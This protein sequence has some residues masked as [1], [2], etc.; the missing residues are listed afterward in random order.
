MEQEACHADDHVTDIR[1]QKD[2][3][4]LIPNTTGYANQ[5]QVNKYRICQCVHE[6]GDV[7]RDIVVLQNSISPIYMSIKL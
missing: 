6:F 1:H 7:D 3:W 5:C 2:T 4:M